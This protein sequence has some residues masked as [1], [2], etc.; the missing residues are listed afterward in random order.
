MPLETA[1]LI[2][3]S[4]D[5]VRA[6]GQIKR[7]RG[8][9][10][11]H[12][13]RCADEK[14]SDLYF[15]VKFSN[16]PQS[17]RVLVNDLFCSVLARRLALPVPQVGV[18]SVHPDLVKYTPALH[19]ELPCSRVPCDSGLQFGSPYVGDVRTDFVLNELFDHDYRHIFN[20][21]HFIGMLAFDVWTCN[22]DCRQAVFLQ[23]VL[24]IPDADIGGVKFP[25]PN[26]GFNAFMIDQGSCFNAAEWNFPNPASGINTMIYSHTS[27]YDRVTD[28]DSFEPYLTNIQKSDI[29]TSR[30]ISASLPAEW[31]VDGEQD[32]FDRVLLKLDARRG[33]L[34]DLLLSLIRRKRGCFKNWKPKL[35]IFTPP[36][37]PAAAPKGI[38]AGGL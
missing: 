3:T 22:T 2:G 16:N 4:V 28:I 14:S 26:V 1:R 17:R 7:L 25:S 8:G 6:T 35:S 9:S 31:F 34:P 37:S 32:L 10:Q 12:L 18:V 23:S 13:M 29:E 11:P 38:P 15:V 21:K 24:E 5:I 33:Q 19:V 30:R 27:V 36:K 20:L